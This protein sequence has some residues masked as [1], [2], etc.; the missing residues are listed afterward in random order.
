M[1]G[2]NIKKVVVI[3]DWDADGVVSAAQIYYAQRYREQF[4]HKGRAKLFIEPSGPRSFQEK[5]QEIEC[6]DYLVILD[7][8]YTQEVREGLK[9]YL[10]RCGKPSG[11]ALYFDHHDTTLKNSRELQE[12]MGILLFYGVM[13]TSIIVKNT[14]EAAGIR[15]TP[16]LRNFVDGVAVL[17]GR[18][19]SI[20]GQVSKNIVNLTASI[21]KTLNRKR[22]PNVWR[23]YVEWLANPLPFDNTKL[24]GVG[25]SI[26]DLSLEESREADEEVRRVAT[27]LAMS[28]VKIGL[29]AFVDA[30]NKWKRP[31]ASAL[32]SHIHKI[33][34]R[35]VALLVERDDGVRVLILRSSAGEART[36]V[37]ELEV[38]KIVEDVGGHENVATARL[39]EEATVERLM[40]GLRR[41]SINLIV[42]RNRG[43]D[44]GA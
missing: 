26:V 19:K 27:D 1:K 41:A 31:G 25:E 42:R 10:E 30:R 43:P 39:V 29:V 9:S 11:S 3:A 4:P 8:P 36:I 6:G 22:D 18:G 34:K 20:G 21:S 35:P 38:M 5:S 24:P 16:R 17:E 32:A 37:G 2:V 23:S 44:P 12:E 13:P 7:I 40:N 15:L 14:L 33:I 28:A